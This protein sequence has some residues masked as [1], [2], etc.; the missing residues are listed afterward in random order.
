MKTIK[1][2]FCSIILIL[3]ASVNAQISNE[4]GYN[5][6]DFPQE[7]LYL[8]LN[9][10]NLFVGE[11][12]MYKIYLT[13]EQKALSKFSKIAYIIL[14]SP[15]KEIV[16]RQ[17]VILNKGVGFSD[18]FIPTNIQTGNYKLIAYTKMG[19]LNANANSFV[20]DLS[21]INPFI[22]LNKNFVSVE[23]E[24]SLTKNAD[25]KIKTINGDIQIK[26]S[27]SL[28]QKRSKVEIEILINTN[29]LF[30]NYSLSIKKLDD[31][32]FYN[33]TNILK[34]DEYLKKLNFSNSFSVI[35]E[36]RGEIITGK[37]STKQPHIPVNNQGLSLIIPD[38]DYILLMGKTDQNG[39][40][41]FNIDENYSSKSF[42]LQ[43]LNAYENQYN[44]TLEE[45]PVLDWSKL[46]FDKLSLAR[47]LKS[48]IENKSTKIQ[49]E[50]SY[51]S[52]RPNKI[53]TVKHELFY[54]QKAKRYNLDEYTRFPSLNETFVE[55]INEAS[56]Q[57]NK[58]KYEIK[59]RAT[60][61]TVRSPLK[62]LVLVN[63]IVIKQHSLLYDFNAFDVKYIDV[64]EEKYFYGG[65]Q[66]QG[67]V[68]IKTN[69][70]AF[71]NLINILNLKSFE[72][73]SP[74]KINKYHKVNYTDNTNLEKIPDF[75]T[76]L[77][78]KPQLEI[79]TLVTTIDLFTSDESGTYE[80]V[81]EGMSN[82]G[83]KSRAT[84]FFKV[85]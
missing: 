12:L 57:K 76:Q 40:F 53:D 50:N 31:F 61:Y 27:D 8:H 65:N 10:N 73:L 17:K 75:R 84:A 79:N 22:S 21:I 64:I 80:I 43:A 74:E 28:Y 82:E 24:N 13:T 5:S 42:F 63:G 67:V 18:I 2:I 44:F 7:N 51:Y 38:E 19:L 29:N 32:Q 39:R 41:Y 25:F 11:R 20:T 69:N 35:P 62:P 34:A 16:T 78:W 46:L 14:I 1:S 58:D 56:F 26:P 72:I 52:V 66:F 71:E 81:I 6:K 23:D 54:G 9:T 55:I 85:K 77:L 30:G 68:S 15:Q 33:Q 3:T 36:L 60:D 49:I 59:V 47:N 4:K 83:K 45:S 48:K 70:K 37:I